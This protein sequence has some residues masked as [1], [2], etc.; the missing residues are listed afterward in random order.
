MV[1]GTKKD[2]SFVL[3][4]DKNKIESSTEVILLGIKI[5]KQLKFK[6]HIEEL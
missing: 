4:I 3:N 1:L 6:S 5:D 2:D